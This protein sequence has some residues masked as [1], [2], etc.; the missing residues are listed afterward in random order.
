MATVYT[1]Y[2]FNIFSDNC[3][4]LNVAIK[5]VATHNHEQVVL[6]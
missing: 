5:V 2:R 6:L 3:M 4:R 1:V